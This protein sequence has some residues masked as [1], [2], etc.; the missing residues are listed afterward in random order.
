[1]KKRKLV[2]LLLSGALVFGLLAGCG[3]GT[4]DGGN[5]PAPQGSETPS[6][7]DEPFEMTLNI[8]SEPQSI[9]P[10][11]NTAVD[12]AIMLSHMFEGLMRWADSGAET[13]GSNGTCN[14]A[15]VVPG[16]AE[17]YEKV[18]N[19]DGTVTYTFK[20]RSDAKWS[21]GKPVTAQ[22]FV[23]TSAWSTLRP[24]LTTAT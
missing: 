1:M 6:A 16:Q 22:D 5:S 13:P 19:E 9:D 10:A 24:P 18:T 20:L 4:Q 8:A 21:D 15:E 2:S 3:G 7:G 12:G 23:F 17:S 14:N 11:L